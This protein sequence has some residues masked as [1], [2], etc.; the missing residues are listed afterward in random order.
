M[1]ITFSSPARV[2]IL[3][4]DSGGHDVSDL[5]APMFRNVPYAVIEPSQLVGY[6]TPSVLLRAIY[7]SLVSRSVVVGYVAALIQKM[8]PKIVITFVDNSALFQRVARLHRNR[9]P[10]FLAIQNGVRIMVRDKPLYHSEFAC[11]GQHDVDQHKSHGVP[12]NYYYPIGSL[13]DAYYRERQPRPPASKRFD[14]CLISQIKPQHYQTYPR[15]MQSLALLAQHLKRFCESHGTTLCIAARRHPDLNARLFEWEKSWFH[16]QIGTWAEV[17]PNAPGEFTSYA[18][19]DRSRVSLAQ[20]TTLLYE[21]FGRGNRVMSCNF[22]GDAQYDFPVE[23]P[24]KFNKCDYESFETHLLQLLSMRDDEYSRLIGERQRYF[25]GYDATVPTHQ[26]LQ[27]LI[28][29]AVQGMPPRQA[30]FSCQAT[31]C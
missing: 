8:R 19:V 2:P 4:I 25:I 22:T 5:L 20:H 12:V 26:F 10:R 3:V 15:T 29:E 28:A 27:E 23:G 30:G 6:L 24:W 16:E 18:L 9:A 21:G 14:L 13:R 1:D 7:Y 11:L 17:I 31:L